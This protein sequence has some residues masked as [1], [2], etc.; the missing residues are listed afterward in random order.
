[1]NTNTNYI[2][3]ANSNPN[4]TLSTLMVNATVGKYIEISMFIEDDDISETFTLQNE[5]PNNSNF[6]NNTLSWIPNNLET[7]NISYVYLK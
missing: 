2:Y 4:I 1:M 6:I 7:Q 5:F 3:S